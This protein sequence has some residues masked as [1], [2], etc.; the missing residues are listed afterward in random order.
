MDENFDIFR[1]DLFSQIE[2][3]KNLLSIYFLNCQICILVFLWRK[4][5]LLIYSHVNMVQILYNEPA[6]E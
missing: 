5:P 6:D 3:L 2:I 4:N 1:V